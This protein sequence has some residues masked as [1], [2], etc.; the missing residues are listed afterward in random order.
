MRSRH[1]KTLTPL[2]EHVKAT[3]GGQVS[4]SSWKQTFLRVWMVLGALTFLAQCST[5]MQPMWRA[6]K[7]SFAAEAPPSS[8]GHGQPPH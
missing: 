1:E 6:V 2:A 4:R 8:S 5:R 3:Q 7:A